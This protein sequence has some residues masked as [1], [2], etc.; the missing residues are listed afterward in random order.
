M[1]LSMI[2]FLFIQTISVAGVVFIARLWVANS[3]KKD[4][5]NYKS[6]LNREVHRIQA[7]LDKTLLV[8]RVQ[9]ETE[10]GALRV[11]WD[12]ITEFRAAS[13][14]LQTTYGMEL[15]W[16]S[17]L[18]AQAVDKGNIEFVEATN[19]LMK[20]VHSQ[21]PFYSGK[22]YDQCFQLISLSQDELDRRGP[23]GHSADIQ[24]LIALLQ[25]R[26]RNIEKIIKQSSA[27]SEKIRCRLQ[28]LTTFR[29][30]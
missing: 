17:E 20:E 14:G 11:I 28:E 19:Q 15:N 26:E 25:D 30:G 29:T 5:E 21:S 1:E 10:F 9:F 16:S 22:I 6:E 4:I 24:E 8:H 13:D 23:I 7:E 27:I 2:D 18:P 3:F 12:K